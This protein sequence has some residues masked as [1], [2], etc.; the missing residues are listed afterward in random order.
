MGL[1]DGYFDPDQFG[2]GGGLLGRLLALQQQQGPYQP[3]AD[4]DQTPAAPQTSAP[5]PLPWPNWLGTG[6]TASA[7]QPP[8]P[9]LRSQY[10]ALRPVL[11]DRNAILAA[12]SPE[13]GQTLIAQALASRQNPANSGNAGSTGDG[14]PAASDASS[15]P[16]RPGSQYAQAAMGLCAAG[17]AGCAAGAGITAGQAILSGLGALGGL[18]AIVLNNENAI[19]PPAGSRPI[20][21]TD[22]SGDHGTIKKAVEANPTDDVR[23]SP[24]GDVWAQNPDGSWTNHG[25]ADTFTG[26][27]KASGRQG[28]DRDR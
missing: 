28:K 13:V 11:G 5:T 24:T 26:S 20:N 21:E 2:N 14:Q 12:V 16:V 23:I 25:P 10:Q 8:L 27:G 15:D 3:G 6:L 22:W 7:A 17:P 18:G 19:R 4:L 1:F 9:D